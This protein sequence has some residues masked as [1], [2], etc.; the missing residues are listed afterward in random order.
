MG[1]LFCQELL[2]MVVRLIRYALPQWLMSMNF[3]AELPLVPR[4]MV[5]N[6]GGRSIHVLI[7]WKKKQREARGEISRDLE[8]A[9]KQ[10]Q[11]RFSV[12][13]APDWSLRCDTCDLFISDDFNIV[14]I[15]KLFIRAYRRDVATKSLTGIKG[16]LVKTYTKNYWSWRFSDELKVFGVTRYYLQL[17]C[18]SRKFINTLMAKYVMH[19]I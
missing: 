1:A 3:K 8:A 9:E 6:N 16:H 5:V 12:F 15:R 13:S 2:T 14:M 11:H 17:N 10:T 18:V 7:L 4:A 19:L